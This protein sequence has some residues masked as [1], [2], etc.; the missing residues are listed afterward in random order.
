MHLDRQIFQAH[1]NSAGG[2]VGAFQG[3]FGGFV[4]AAC[5]SLDVNR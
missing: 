1:G 3:Y 5:E 4:L 2:P